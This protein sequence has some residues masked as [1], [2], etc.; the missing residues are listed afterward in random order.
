MHQTGIRSF[1]STLCFPA[2]FGFHRYCDSV[3]RVP[4]MYIRWFL[5]SYSLDLQLN[6]GKDSF[7]KYCVSGNAKTVWFGG[8]S[9]CKSLSEQLWMYICEKAYR[10]TGLEPGPFNDCY[11][12]SPLFTVIGFCAGI[13]GLGENSWKPDGLSL[14]VCLRRIKSESYSFQSRL[15]VTG[16]YLIGSRSTLGR[17]QKRNNLRILREYTHAFSSHLPFGDLPLQTWRTCRSEDP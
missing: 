9:S 16:A 3:V 4:Y 2:R 12:P 7:R 17:L 8:D 10:T 11:Q 6:V 14:A 1:D 5:P 13:P 15:C